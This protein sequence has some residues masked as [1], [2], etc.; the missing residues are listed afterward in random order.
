MLSPV[1][2]RVWTSWGPECHSEM[3]SRLGKQSKKLGEPLNVC[4][5]ACH[6]AKTFHKLER[7]LAKLLF[8]FWREGGEDE[9]EH[10]IKFDAAFEDGLTITSTVPHGMPGCISA[11][12]FT[13]KPTGA[14][15]VV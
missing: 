7:Q 3:S 5:R 12:E 14:Q 10:R 6:W 9:A 15:P 2:G 4:K 13:C 11:P 1:P 8:K